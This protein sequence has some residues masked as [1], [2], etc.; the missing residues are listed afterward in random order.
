MVNLKFIE[1]KAVTLAILANY[2]SCY[3]FDLL[4]FADR[5]DY[6]KQMF[7]AN[8]KLTHCFKQWTRKAGKWS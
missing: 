2:A 1:S 6:Q 3:E 4:D 7:N 8:G 5:I